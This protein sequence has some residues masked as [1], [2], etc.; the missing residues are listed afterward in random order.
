[1]LGDIV[2]RHDISH[3]CWVQPDGVWVGPKKTLSVQRYRT[4]VAAD[5]DRVAGLMQVGEK[6]GGNDEVDG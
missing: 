6:V 1:M 2:E 5:D 4:G 3:S